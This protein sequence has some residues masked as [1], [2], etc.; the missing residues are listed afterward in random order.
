MLSRLL[1]T[2]T[3]TSSHHT[4]GQRIPT[5]RLEPLEARELPATVYGLGAVNTLVQFDSAAPNAPAS[6]GTVRYPVIRRGCDCERFCM[7]PSLR[8][9]PLTVLGKTAGRL[10][11]R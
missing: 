6:C 7:R 3:R 10:G 1:R 8:R 11:E 4:R 9:I 2:L 5:L